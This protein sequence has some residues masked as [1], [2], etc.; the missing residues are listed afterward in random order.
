MDIY[1]KGLS[2]K[3]VLGTHVGLTVGVKLG[4]E[5]KTA[6]P[7]TVELHALRLHQGAPGQMPW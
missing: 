5:V 1:N 2:D 7:N 4:T 6:E 3:Y